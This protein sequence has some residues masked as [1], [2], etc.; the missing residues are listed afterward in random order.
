MACL[1]IPG[2]TRFLSHCQ[3]IFRIIISY[4]RKIRVL[5]K[6]KQIKNISDQ[7]IGQGNFDL[8]DVAFSA[9][10]VAHVGEKTH[11]GQA[12]IKQFTKQLRTAIPDIEIVRIEIKSLTDNLLTCQRTLKGT[13]KSGLKGIP[14]SN[15]KIGW[16]EMVVS[17]FEKERHSGQ[18]RVNVVF[19]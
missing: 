14:A 2:K 15:K 3:K 6:C 16:Y 4:N 10:Y 9:A 7:L 1:V 19:L 13:H 11:I 5:L 17:R 12:F 18:C 8:I